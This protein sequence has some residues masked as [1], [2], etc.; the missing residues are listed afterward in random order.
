MT[1]PTAPAAERITESEVKVYA[2]SGNIELQVD[3]SNRVK[4]VTSMTLRIYIPDAAIKKP[5]NSAFINFAGATYAMIQ[6]HSYESTVVTPSQIGDY[7]MNIIVN[8]QDGTTDGVNFT[9]SVGPAGYV[10][11]IDNGQVKKVEG[12]R[13]S[14]YADA[15]GG[16]YGLWNGAGSGQTNPQTTG[17]AGTYS[18]ILPTGTYK[19]VAD[20]DGYRTKE[21]LPFPVDVG[22]VISTDLELIK[23]PPPPVEKI[24]EI[25]GGT[26]TAGVKAGMIAGVVAEQGRYAA[27]VT[28]DQARE[29][30]NNPIVQKQTEQ[31][32]APTVAVVAAANVAAAGAASAN[33]APF[34]IYLYSFLAHPTLLIGRR[35]RKKWGMV[36]NSLSKLPV[37]LAIVRLL[38]A[39]TARIVR[40]AVTDKEGRYFFIVQPGEYRISAVKAGHVFPSD[41]LKGQREDIELVDLYHGE[42]IVVSQETIITANIPLDPVV[43]EK[44]TRKIV[45]EG[46]GRRLQK[47]VGVLTILAMGLAA[48]IKP[49]P[50][51]IGL[52]V[53]NI[54]LYVIFK[55][56]SVS[57][58]PKSWGIV[59]DEKS[60]KPIRNAVARIFEAKYNK[61]LETQIT[62]G[63]GHYSFL[64]GSNVYYVTFEKAGYRKQQ[65]GPVDL[66]KV[67]MK[68]KDEKI[69]TLD[70]SLAPVMPGEAAAPLAPRVTPPSAPT[71]QA[72]PSAPSAPIVSSTP[73]TPPTP[74]AK[75][76]WE[77]DVLARLKKQGGGGSGSVPP[78]SAPPTPPPAPTAPPA[79]PSQAAATT[80]PETSP[81]MIQ[82]A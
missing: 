67:D 43:V 75:A 3:R 25:L 44:Q 62:D 33:A 68:K 11:E 69:V 82:D 57:K 55:R 37:D 17:S 18:Y 78:V 79:A 58:R 59:Y 24:Q 7:P 41:F 2:T 10:Y 64:V 8:Y 51:V 38:D 1:T 56:L 71:T 29:I 30:R 36:Y 9:V 5:I 74:T 4:V 39:K 14:L 34:A 23:V 19:L 28:Y 45:L 66:L 26:Q 60:K 61:L 73:P 76:G 40:S 12:A 35:R 52:F 21:T 48:I 50:I 16:N 20:K 31:V 22:A 81:P 65:Q 53:A 32:A 15:G 27:R 77:M 70:V 46:I 49:S 6:T 13:V 63:N 80:T 47:S 42:P 72:P 54:A